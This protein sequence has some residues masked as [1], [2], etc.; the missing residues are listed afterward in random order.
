MFHTGLKRFETS[1]VNNFTSHTGIR[2]RKLIHPIWGP[3]LKAFTA[4][5][6]IVEA[7]PKLEKEKAYI[8]AV[9]HS[10]DEDIISALQTVDRGAYM[11]FGTTDQMEHNPLC[12]LLW[13]YG[14]IY[15]N[16][17][18]KNSRNDAIKKMAKILQS[19][20]SVI[21][22][23]EGAYNNSENQ[24]IM[25]LFSSPY[26]LNKELGIEVVPM[27]S[28][29]DSGSD[30][31]YIHVG[32]PINLAQYEKYEAMEILR[33]EMCTIVYMML[34]KHTLPLKRKDLGINP[35]MAY[36]EERQK[37][38]E[39]QKWHGDV[40]D[41]ELSYYSGHG[42]TTPQQSRLYVDRI[43]VTMKNVQVLTDTLVRREEDKCYDFKEHLRKNMKLY[44]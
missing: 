30:K 23:P 40:W 4:K 8:F 42:V 16:R 19:G 29:N 21:L 32:N 27:I 13:A 14:M 6:V 35:R 36:M 28:F 37:V 1:D 31:I 5:K 11:L 9:N 26:I 18:D 38:Y 33:D 12:L 20:S 7:Y 44:T 39:Y 41:E 3:L 34:E 10:F 22:F 2:L 15:V 43:N 17:L 25:P 24:L